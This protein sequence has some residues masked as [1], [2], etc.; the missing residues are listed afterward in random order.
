[1]I[2][3]MALVWEG[4]VARWGLWGMWVMRIWGRR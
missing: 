4:G 1:M 3:R 2:A